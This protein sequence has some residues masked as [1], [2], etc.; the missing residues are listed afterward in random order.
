M[1]LPAFE[2]QRKVLAELRA[3]GSYMGLNNDD[4]RRI[5]KEIEDTIGLEE[6]YE[7]ERQTVEKG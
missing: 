1:M 4:A 5:R 3:T 7:I 6:F 2:A